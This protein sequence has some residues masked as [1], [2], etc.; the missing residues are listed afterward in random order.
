MILR[1]LYSIGIALV[2]ALGVVHNSR[3][4]DVNSLKSG[5]VRI[6]NS[7]TDE[8]GYRLHREN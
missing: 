4:Q 6:H 3:A 8:V 1:P 2:V 7:Q 5:V